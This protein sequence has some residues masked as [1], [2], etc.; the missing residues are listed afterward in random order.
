[1][2]IEIPE[3]ELFKAEVLGYLPEEYVEPAVKVIESQN[4]G[5]MGK[6]I[7]EILPKFS[8]IAGSF[9]LRRLMTMGNENVKL[10]TIRSEEVNKWIKA[11]Q[12]EL[13]AAVFK[14]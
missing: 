6:K 7:N 1:M 5:E 13:N 14:K 10:A 4:P 11:H 9:L 2:K 8:G 3:A 12:D